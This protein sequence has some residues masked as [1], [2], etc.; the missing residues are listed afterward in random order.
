MD[1]KKAQEQT[2]KRWLAIIA[3]PADAPLNCGWC[4]F[5]I[6]MTTRDMHQC[7]NC[8]VVRVFGDS[9]C[10][11]KEYLDWDLG[12]ENTEEARKVYDLLVAHKHHLIAAAKEI[13]NEQ[14]GRENSTS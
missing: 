3:N 14:S 12:G 10:N 9:C 2:E 5:A 4:V 8:P 11:I 13:E 6:R 1:A 7:H